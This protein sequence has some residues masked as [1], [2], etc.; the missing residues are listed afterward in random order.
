MARWTAELIHRVEDGG[1]WGVTRGEGATAEA[2]AA[3]AWG[4]DWW[5]PEVR[6][7]VELHLTDTEAKGDAGQAGESG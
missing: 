3:E 5:E 6:Y 1:S 4:Q 7:V 2:A